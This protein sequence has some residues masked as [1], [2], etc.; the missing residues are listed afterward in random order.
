M[1]SMRVC[2]SYFPQSLKIVPGQTLYKGIRVWMHA[3]IVKECMQGLCM[4]ACRDCEGMHV[5]I[6]YGCMQRLCMDA[7]RDCVWM[8]AG[9]VYGC[10]RV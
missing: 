3:G 4:D 8:H 9:I 5:G 7:C 6:V 2:Q 1:W 10:M